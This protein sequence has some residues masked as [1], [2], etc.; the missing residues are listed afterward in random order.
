MIHDLT[1]SLV[2]RFFDII[3]SFF[4]LLLLLPLFI[5]ITFFVKLDNPGPVFFI[6]QRIGRNFRSFRLYKFR[7]MV[8]DASKKGLAI[9]TGGDLRITKIGKLLRKTKMDELPQL[10]NVLKGDM[11][12]VGPRP[13]VKKYVE[14]FK[15]DY[16]EVLKVKPGIADYATIEFRDEESVLKKFQNPEDGYIKEVL[17]VKIKLYNRYLKNR[18]FFTDLKLIFLTLWKIV[19]K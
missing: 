9:T 13:E 18:G 5:L 11:S 19:R 14:M 1:S 4:V 2:K 17:P 6:Q 7:S 15:D 3:T 10:W 12:I 8:V 16:K